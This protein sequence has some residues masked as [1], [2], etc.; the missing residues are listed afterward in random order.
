MKD[1]LIPLVIVLLLATLVGLILF[2]L[3]TPATII[4]PISAGLFGTYPAVTTN[5]KERNKTRQER[6]TAWVAR[7]I[8]LNPLLVSFFVICYLQF[9]E[10]TVGLFVGAAIGVA[11][12]ISGLLDP[13]KLS[14]VVLAVSPPLTLF[15]AMFMIAPIAKYASH[16]IKRFPFL[17]IIASLLLNQVVDFVVAG[18]VLQMQIELLN[19]IIVF[20]LLLPGAV[21]GR[22]WA[23]RTQTTYVMDNLFR[24]LS[25]SDQNALID[26]AQTLPGQVT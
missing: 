12:G 15:I 17:W 5:L 8:Y 20:V 10:R 3:G 25:N 4:T 6:I 23:R 22:Y 24:Q 7:N 14:S 21:V 19:Q 18:F 16:R 11:L 26:L 9:I 1:A 13:S 2:F